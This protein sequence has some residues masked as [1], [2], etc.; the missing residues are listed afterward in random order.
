MVS[1][2]LFYQSLTLTLTLTF[3][4]V[5]HPFHRFPSSDSILCNFGRVHSAKAF[6]DYY[7]AMCDD[8]RACGKIMQI[9][10]SKVQLQRPETPQSSG[11]RKTFDQMELR[12][13]TMESR[14]DNDSPHSDDGPDS[15]VEIG[16]N[17]LPI[18]DFD[19]FWPIRPFCA[20][21]ELF[22]HIMPILVNF[23]PFGHIL[24][25]LLKLSPFWDIHLTFI[26][27]ADINKF[28][29]LFNGQTPIERSKSDL[30]S[31]QIAR[32]DFDKALNP[33][34]SMDTMIK[35]PMITRER[36]IDPVRQSAG[37]G[38]PYGQFSAPYRNQTPR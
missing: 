19:L 29:A 28:A 15:R 34:Q 30:Q 27:L 9:D 12:P 24:P 35:Q 22:G 11:L 21:L 5:I 25:I 6:P 32:H 31:R 20:H 14:L 10:L 26:L 13:N 36:S 7:L 18:F 8:D 16:F 38:D 1:M 33:R 37:A 2:P 17:I 4:E 23:V 3:R